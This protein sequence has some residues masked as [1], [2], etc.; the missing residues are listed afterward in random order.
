MARGY[1]KRATK[2][3]VYQA[4]FK[5]QCPIVKASLNK[6]YELTSGNPHS[7]LY[8]LEIN[9]S[10]PFSP[11]NV[12][13]NT[14]GDELGTWTANDS[15]NEPLGLDSRMYEFYKY[16]IVKGC[17]VSATI[18]YAPDVPDV[19][20]ASLTTG[21]ITIARSSDPI[22][23]L[24]LPTSSSIKQMYGAK[25]RNFQLPG[26]VGQPGIL[27]KNAYVSNGYSAKKQFH[28]SSVANEDLR[29]E[30]L[31]GSSNAPHDNTYLY[32][33]IKPQ[34]DIPAG[35]LPLYLK[36]MQVN[37]KITYIL[38]YIDPT[39]EQQIPLPL[40]YKSGATRRRI[41]RGG[42]SAKDAAQDWKFFKAIMPLMGG[43]GGVGWAAQRAN[44]ALG[45]GA[46]RAIRM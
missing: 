24:T 1:R 40:N 16:V 29:V 2:R 6:Q 7:S 15:Y 39:I 18:Q 32:I 38:Q 20:Q 8:G 10:T 3:N 36:P 41:R 45:F 4:N 21:Q 35:E 13:K 27:T 17:H 37:V 26:T 25:T 23:P 12:V 22:N 19:P 14:A 42:Y 30:N 44:R 33:L 34:R 31:T 46:R 43:Y 11:L 28:V 5:P 9:A